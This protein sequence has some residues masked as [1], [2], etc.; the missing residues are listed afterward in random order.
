MLGGQRQVGF[1]TDQ[2]VRIVDQLTPDNIANESKV[3]YTVLD[4]DTL[5]QV[6]KD[7]E[8]LNSGV[9]NGVTWHFFTSPVTGLGGPSPTLYNALT[10][11]G[12]KMVIHK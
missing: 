11:A 1:Q 3:G 8:L 10:N 12:I 6:S 5:L 9:V 2:G 7:T 4:A